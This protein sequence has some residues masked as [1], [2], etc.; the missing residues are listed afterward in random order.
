MD[1]FRNGRTPFQ[2]IFVRLC[3]IDAGLENEPTW[4]EGYEF[5]DRADYD[6][7]MRTLLDN[8]ADINAIEQ[9]NHDGWA[10]VHHAARLGNYKRI[11]FFLENGGKVSSTDR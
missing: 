4:Q 2:T 3:W 1:H 11:K 10:T 8:G 5:S 7:V 6:E 9:R